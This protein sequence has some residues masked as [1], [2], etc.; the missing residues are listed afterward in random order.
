MLVQPSLRAGGETG[1]RDLASADHHDLRVPLRS[2][3]VAV[4]VHVTEAVVLADLLQ[5]LEVLQQRR[6]TAPEPD[7]RGGQFVVVELSGRQRTGYLPLL[8]R[9]LV[10][11][12]LTARGIDVVLV[13]VRLESLLYRLDAGLRG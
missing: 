2:N 7:V 12:E 11:P 10:G 4:H 3:G 13:I 5:R 6:D 8:F 1:L 9:D